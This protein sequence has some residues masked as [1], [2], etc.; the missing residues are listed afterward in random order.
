MKKITSIIAWVA[1]IGAGFLPTDAKAE[2]MWNFSQSTLNYLQNIKNSQNEWY[3]N[4]KLY[5]NSWENIVVLKVPNDTKMDNNY[6]IN[7]HPDFIA[8]GWFSGYKIVL[9][10]EDGMNLFDELLKDNPNTNKIKQLSDNLIYG[11]VDTSGSISDKS[12]IIKS[13]VNQ[14]ANMLSKD[15]VSSKELIEILDLLST[16]MLGD[17]ASE[18]Q[19]DKL[20]SE[21]QDTAPAYIY[22]D[23]GIFGILLFAVMLYILRKRWIDSKFMFSLG[24]YAKINKLST[25]NQETK[26]YNN[27]INNN[28]LSDDNL[29]RVLHNKDVNKKFSAILMWWNQDF[30]D[31]N[32]KNIKL[33]GIKNVIKE[34]IHNWIKKDK[35][36]IIIILNDIYLDYKMPMNLAINANNYKKISNFLTNNKEKLK[37]N[38]DNIKNAINL[39]WGE[40]DLESDDIAFAMVPIILGFL[41]NGNGYLSDYINIINSLWSDYIYNTLLKWGKW[42]INNV[43]GLLANWK[44]KEIKNAIYELVESVKNI[45]ELTKN[46]L[47]KQKDDKR[48]Q[49]PIMQKIRNEDMDLWFYYTISKYEDIEAELPIYH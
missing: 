46:D 45:F 12:T 19:I 3:K 33:S 5:L 41:N 49:E 31:I 47:I 26:M 13:E 14:I 48:Q 1:S 22:K 37:K 18:I 28:L 35:I 2:V 34:V 7:S 16:Q 21:M 24:K 32:D 20:I 23:F 8:N 30:I 6:D 11:E 44:S 17:N 25:N 39:I 36:E 29:S 4:L 27:Y 10:N 40:F 43:V 15:N 42:D 9:I 38:A